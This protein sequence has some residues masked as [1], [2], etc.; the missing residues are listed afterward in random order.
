L[1][2]L[3][4]LRRSLFNP[5]SG[6]I[7]AAGFDAFG[8]LPPWALNTARNGTGAANGSLVRVTLEHKELPMNS[9]KVSPVLIGTWSPRSLEDS[10]VRFT[11]SLSADGLEV[12]AVDVFDGERLEVSEL[13]TRGQTLRFSTYTP[14]T[15][16]TLHHELEATAGGVRHRF[17]APDVRRS[18]TEQLHPS[19]N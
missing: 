19:A 11:V 6:G 9:S 5:D 18:V 1:D 3:C 17:S 10:N 8:R 15:G 4:K 2:N 16:A 12:H 7:E 13:V 14:S